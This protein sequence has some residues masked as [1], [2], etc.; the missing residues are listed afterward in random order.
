MAAPTPR[1]RIPN[2]LLRHAAQRLRETSGDASTWTWLTATTKA[3]AAINERDPDI[4]QPQRSPA[5]AVSDH[6]SVFSP[7][8]GTALASWL[9]HH[10]LRHDTYGCDE[11]NETS[12]CPAVAVARAII[13]EDLN[14][15]L[16]KEN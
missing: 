6:L 15:A 14:E 4:Y 5:L 12:T 8:V 1:P 10:A 3:V 9:E 16:T 11:D 7:L 2:D 13:L